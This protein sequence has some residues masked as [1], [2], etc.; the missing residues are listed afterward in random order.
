M[1]IIASPGI[2]AKHKNPYTSMLYEQMYEIGVEVNEATPR[3]IF[4]GAGIAIWHFHWPEGALNYKSTVKVLFKLF[5]LFSQIYW[6]KLR[7]VRIVWTVHNLQAHEQLHPKIEAWFWRRFL[8]NLDGAI[9]LSESGRALSF[10]AHPILQSKPNFV[11]AHGH[12]KGRYPDVVT[13]TQ[14]RRRLGYNEDNALAL[15]LGH[16][17]PYKNAISLVEAFKASSSCNFRLLIA[18]TPSSDEMRQQL[19]TACKGEERITTHLQFI[20]TEDIQY[21]LR[22][23]DIMVLPY[24]TILNSGVALLA[25]SFDCPVLAPEKGSLVD[26][27]KQVGADWVRLFNAQLTSDVLSRALHWSVE[28]RG[29][30]PN[31]HAHDRNSVAKDTLKAYM[32]ILDV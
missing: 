3:K 13:R 2:R 5:K 1:Q 11:I 10:K 31:L 26:L 6:V 22:A 27:Q 23:A 18:G 12:Y 17:R 15:F 19:E 25:L 29:V 16:L 7:R 21:Y 28:H 9:N 8:A 30:S 32:S 14:A 4:F 24:E 20:S